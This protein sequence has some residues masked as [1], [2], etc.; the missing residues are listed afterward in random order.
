M[1]DFHITCNHGLIINITTKRGKE[2]PSSDGN[3][4]C[5]KEMEDHLLACQQFLKESHEVTRVAND[6]A[7]FLKINDIND[8]SFLK[9]LNAVIVVL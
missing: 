2:K 6:R 9:R 8:I 3:C 1:T 7:T 5:K 4:Q